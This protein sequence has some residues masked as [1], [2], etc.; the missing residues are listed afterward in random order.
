M[1]KLSLQAKRLSKL[2]APWKLRR[3]YDD[4]SGYLRRLAISRMLLKPLTS[5]QFHQQLSRQRGL[6]LLAP[7]R[8]TLHYLLQN[9]GV[10]NFTCSSIFM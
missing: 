3:L 1:W 8:V 10:E 2:Q 4:G 7:L 9:G 6:H 5:K